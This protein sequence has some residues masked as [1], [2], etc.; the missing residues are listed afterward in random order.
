M[1]KYQDS[2][3]Q[4]EQAEAIINTIVNVI[5]EMDRKENPCDRTRP[6]SGQSHTD[7]GERGKT[8]VHGLTF[9]DIRDC[10]V[11]GLLQAAGRSGLVEANACDYRDVYGFNLDSIDPLAVA[12]NMAC[13]IEKR[14]GI[15]PN[16]PRLEESPDEDNN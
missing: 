3:E 7:T 5:D 6:Y 16:V 12:N 15:Y 8:E 1:S 14:M 4:Q 11:I 13:E 2:Y 10:F 9:R